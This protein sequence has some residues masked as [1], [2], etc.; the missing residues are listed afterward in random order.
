[1]HSCVDLS[2]SY[3]KK[4]IWTGRDW[5]PDAALHRDL[6]HIKKDVSRTGSKN[7]V[8]SE[9]TMEITEIIQFSA[10]VAHQLQFHVSVIPQCK[11]L[12]SSPLFRSVVEWN[13]VKLSHSLQPNATSLW[14][15]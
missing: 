15:K 9:L 12:Q 5:F 7:K 3:W 8:D 14:L 2:R 10:K 13:S 11:R 4:R 1:M 6:E